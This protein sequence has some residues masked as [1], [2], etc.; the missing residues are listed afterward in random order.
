MITRAACARPSAI[1]M[2]L[3]V[4]ESVASC[5]SKRPA[6]RLFIF[7]RRLRCQLICGSFECKTSRHGI[8]YQARPGRN[9]RDLQNFFHS[10]RCG[11]KVTQNIFEKI[12]NFARK[13]I[14]REKDRELKSFSFARG[15]GSSIAADP[16]RRLLL[17]IQLPLTSEIKLGRRVPVGV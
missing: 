11:I 8:I 1:S 14:E 12:K 7:S 3:E 16:G 4:Y 9:C 2:Q 15:R 13:T 6:S 5:N 10:S 17:T